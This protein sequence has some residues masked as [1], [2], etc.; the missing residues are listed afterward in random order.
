MS[1]FEE[2]S[3]FVKEAEGL[4]VR[5]G[6]LL[7]VTDDGYDKAPFWYNCN[8]GGK[9]DLRL[10][11]GFRGLEGRGNCSRCNKEYSFAFGDPETPSLSEVKS[12]V[13][14]R[15]I[16]ILLTY[17]RALGISCFTSG[18]GGLGY[19]I[20]A[21][22]IAYKLGIPFPP[23]PV[24]RP[25]DKYLGVAQLQALLQFKEISGSFDIGLSEDLLARSR[26]EAALLGKKLK[27]SRRSAVQDKVSAHAD[28]KMREEKKETAKK[29]SELNR[30][31]RLLEKVP[32]SL[33]VIPSIIDYAVNVGL[34]ETSD[35][36]GAF[37]GGEGSFFSDVELQSVF[38]D[39]G[40]MEWL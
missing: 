24:W 33:N 5:R 26:K 18:V 32:A 19:L 13:S 4:L 11:P 14:S 37:L 10:N 3:E 7:N 12:Q 39:F 34:K 35:Q 9:V 21:R 31:A 40:L 15:S 23:S 20:K 30:T 38:A 16:S 6:V 28:R 17:F 36:W 25:R 22:H 27:N 8:C 2:F 29:L 1:R